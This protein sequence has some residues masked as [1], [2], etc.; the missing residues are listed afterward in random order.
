M[1]NWVAR[2]PGFSAEATLLS[3][4]QHR[5]P[6][7]ALQH[8]AGCVVSPQL[9]VKPGVCMTLNAACRAGVHS[10]CQRARVHGC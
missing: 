3:H 6:T 5:Y 7:L 8:V 9:S 10:A 4:E 1:N 2:L